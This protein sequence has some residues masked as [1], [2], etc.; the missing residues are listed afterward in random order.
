MVSQ[1]QQSNRACSRQ[2]ETFMPPDT[3]Q[4]VE[5]HISHFPEELRFASMCSGSGMDHVA[6][7]SVGK[8]LKEMGIK[9][10]FQCVFQ[11][12]KEA[13]KRRWLAAHCQEGAA[14]CSFT[15]VRHI[16]SRECT[17][18]E[19]S[20]HKKPCRVPESDVVRTHILQRFQTFQQQS[21]RQRQNEPNGE[22]V[23]RESERSAI[24]II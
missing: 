2:D 24:N 5:E 17:G 8:V 16:Q 15:D 23:A 20:N 9:T 11:C 6:M 3:A 4:F 7:L 18:G 22:H 12:E 19:C 1:R 14:P 13:E 10:K 21:H